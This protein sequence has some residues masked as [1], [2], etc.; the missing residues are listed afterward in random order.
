MTA[1]KLRFPTPDEP[2]LP[3]DI[4]VH[5]IGRGRAGALT[6]VSDGSEPSVRFCVDR[7]GVWLTVTEG[8]Q[9]VHVNGRQVRRMA[10]LRTGDAIF[11]D[12]H[13]LRLVSTTPVAAIAPAEDLDDADGSD[14]D[15]RTVLRGVGGRYHGRSF[16]LD[17]P[18]LVGRHAEADIRIDEPG[19]A[20]RHARLERVGGFVRLT[21]LGSA[22]GSVVNGEPTRDAVLQAGDQ[23]VFDA[24]HRFVV[25][26][27]ARAGHSAG[28][29]RAPEPQALV[30]ASPERRGGGLPLPWLLL[31]AV[32]LAGLLSALLLFGAA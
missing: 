3:L 2:E 20:D 4:G 26:A 25:E 1:L 27:P 5:G 28:Y 13:E 29:D 6:P 16:T 17:R 14:A 32:V 10:M 12:G 18:R 22:D 21:D 7:R 9:G 30:D 31:A 8:V 24:H 15:P 19:F 11:V 23:V